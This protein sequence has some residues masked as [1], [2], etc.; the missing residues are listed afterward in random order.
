MSGNVGQH[1]VEG[2]NNSWRRGGDCVWPLSWARLPT[3][4]QTNFCST[5]VGPPP[6]EQLGGAHAGGS[7]SALPQFDPLPLSLEILLI[8]ESVHYSLTRLARE[9]HEGKRTC[10]MS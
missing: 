7:L 4:L 5:F 10:V 9:G 8:W 2:T 3:P 1:R 6:L